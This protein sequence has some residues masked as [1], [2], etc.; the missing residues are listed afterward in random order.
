[1]TVEELIKQSISERNR[2][3]ADEA[4]IVM[5]DPESLRR[6]LSGKRRLLADELIALCIDLDLEI[7]D[8][9]SASNFTK[10]GS[11]VA[12]RGAA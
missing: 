12:S 4:R 7:S 2:N 9:K 11:L 3:V 8:L 10:L 6:A 5:L 1:M